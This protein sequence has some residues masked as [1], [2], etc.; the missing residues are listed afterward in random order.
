MQYFR[1]HIDPQILYAFDDDVTATQGE[2][3]SWTFTSGDGT[4]LVGPYPSTLYPSDDPTPPTVI[5]GPAQVDSQRDALLQLA[6]LRIAPMQ[7]AQDLGV[8]TEDEA[9]ALVLWK[10]YRVDL[11][12]VTQQPGYPQAVVWPIEPGATA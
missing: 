5:P 3:G 2:G 9:A 12:R 7:D 6:A 1:D 4:E 10:K 11:N 8:A